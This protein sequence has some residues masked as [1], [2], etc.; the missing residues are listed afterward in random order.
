M[1]LCPM[2]AAA[3]ACSVMYLTAALKLAVAISS[4]SRGFLI[5]LLVVRPSAGILGISDLALI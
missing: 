2:A 1:L 5:A 3:S 4:D